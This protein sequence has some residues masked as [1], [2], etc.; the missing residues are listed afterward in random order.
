LAGAA[1]ASS[2]PAAST[3]ADAPS[4][5][6][7]V[8]EATEFY[9]PTGGMCCFLHCILCPLT[10]FFWPCCL[11]DALG[12]FGGK[13]KC[14]LRAIF[15]EIKQTIEFDH[16]RRM[17]TLREYQAMYCSRGWDLMTEQEVPFDRVD[18][19]KCVK[20]AVIGLDPDYV[21]VLA[22]KPSAASTA[23][24][25]TWPFFI[26][27]A[28]FEGGELL[29]LSVWQSD[30]IKKNARNLEFINDLNLEKEVCVSADSEK[31][32]PI[33]NKLNKRLSRAEGV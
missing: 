1:A 27:R 29:L 12:C 16:D 19:F 32:L 4:S 8:F 25:Y 17:I 7:D 14:G 3:A 23:T 28:I 15:N 21:A 5:R 33:I 20:S 9:D 6:R 10:C 13:N 26:D 11:L 30:A 22:V 18:G 2:P 24:P 31:L